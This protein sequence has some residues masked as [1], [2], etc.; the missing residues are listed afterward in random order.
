MKKLSKAQQQTVDRMREGYNLI[1]NRSDCSVILRLY[2][3]KNKVNKNTFHSLL[4]NGVIEFYFGIGNEDGYVLT[5]Q[6][7]TAPATDT[8]K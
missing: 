6:Y 1:V 8:G 3:N 7:K 2:R 4:N 5:E